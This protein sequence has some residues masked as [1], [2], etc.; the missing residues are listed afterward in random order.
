MM[1]H[2][3]WATKHPKSFG[4]RAPAGVR[5]Q[6]DLIGCAMW[7][8]V[9]EIHGADGFPKISIWSFSFSILKCCLWGSGIHNKSCRLDGVSKAL[10]SP[11]FAAAVT[12]NSPILCTWMIRRR[13]STWRRP[14]CVRR[15][16]AVLEGTAALIYGS[17]AKCIYTRGYRERGRC[18]LP[19]FLFLSF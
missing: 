13:P 7:Q 11:Q 16:A 1:S 3:Y 17:V 19:L 14:V 15:R 18:L 8:P 10:A 4:I 12:S 6:G 5:H 2:H 9:F